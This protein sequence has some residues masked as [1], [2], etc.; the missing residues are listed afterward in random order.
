MQCKLTC[1]GL[2]PLLAPC[3]YESRA[4]GQGLTYSEAETNHQAEHLA[5]AGDAS[6]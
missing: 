2:D 6:L 1:P 3:V 4:L 5:I